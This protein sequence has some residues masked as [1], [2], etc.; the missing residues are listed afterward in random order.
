M[1]VL[2]RP[3]RDGFIF[4][5]RAAIYGLIER[6]SRKF[7]MA[8]QASWEDVIG[9]QSLRMNR[10]CCVFKAAATEWVRDLLG[11]QRDDADCPGSPGG[12]DALS[13]FR[14]GQSV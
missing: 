11:P 8:E 3:E 10:L 2:L 13:D 6:V 9:E 1:R 7:N 14:M 12:D 4:V 5:A